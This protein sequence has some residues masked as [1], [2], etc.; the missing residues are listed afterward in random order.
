MTTNTN[1][2][3]DIIRGIIQDE[4]AK[5]LTQSASPAGNGLSPEPEP[6]QPYHV[7]ATFGE[8]RA[9][10]RVPVAAPRRAPVRT[11]TPAHYRVTRFGASAAGQKLVASLTPRL[12]NTFKAVARRKTGLSRP[13]V[14]A[15]T[16]TTP[17]QAENNVYGLQ[18][19]ELI[20]TFYPDTK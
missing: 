3:S 16:G 19:L 17:K 6:E 4:L 2:L 5:M 1:T 20:E 10:P 12:A 13:D 9:N 15:S 18:R 11:A 7:Q 8:R 14:S